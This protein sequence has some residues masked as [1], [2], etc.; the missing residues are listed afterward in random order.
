MNITLVYATNSGTTMMAAQMVQ[1][2]LTTS[3]HTVIVKVA[4]DTKPED[5][6]AAQAVVFGTP[7]WDFD[8]KEGMPHQDMMTLMES[9]K[10]ETFEN[11]PFAVFGLGDSTYKH[12][13]GAVDHLEEFVKT[14]KGKLVVTSLRIDNFYGDQEGNTDKTT[15]WA[16]TLAGALQ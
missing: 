14:I 8:G 4:R 3:G 2:T 7:S 1:E 12:F 9:L 13:C 6:T 5:I 15:K 10:T 11:K 16:Q